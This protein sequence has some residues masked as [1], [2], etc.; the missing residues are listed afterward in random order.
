MTDRLDADPA[1]PTTTYAT[2]LATD[3]AGR[4][5]SISASSVFSGFATFAYRFDGLVGKRVTPN[6]E[7][8]TFAYDALRRPITITKANGN[9]FS[10]TYDRD[11][12]VLTEAR[13]LTGPTGDNGSNTNTFSYDALGRVTGETGLASARTYQY[14]LD[15]NRTRKIEGTTTPTIDY[16][17]DRT[18]Q[19]IKQKV[20]GGAD[21]TLAYNA[22]GDLLTNRDS[23]GA[24]TTYAYDTASHLKSI[25]SGG[26]TATFAFD[27]LGRYRQR[28]VGAVIDKYRYVGTSETTAVIAG[29]TTR[30]SAVSTDGSRVATKDGSTA[31]YLLPDLH[32]NVAAMEQAGA[33]TI[34]NAIRYDAYGQTMGTPYTA[35]GSIKLDTKYQGRLDVSPGTDPL[36]DMSARFYSPAIGAFTS[37]DSVAGT[38]QNPA[39]MNRFLYALGNPASLIDPTGHYPNPLQICPFGPE[40]CAGLDYHPPPGMTSHG[41]GTASSA[42]SGSGGTARDPQDSPVTTVHTPTTGT[43]HTINPDWP[44]G[45]NR[46]KWINDTLEHDCLGGS[47]RACNLYY[48]PAS[49]MGNSECADDLVACI[50][51]LAGGATLA[52]SGPVIEAGASATVDAATTLVTTAI[53]TLRTLLDKTQ[54]NPPLI[55]EI[56]EAGASVPGYG[57]TWSQ[58]PRIVQAGREYAEM[59]RYLF[60]KHAVDNMLP[61][62]QG[63]RA[64]PPSVVISALENAKPVI[65]QLVDGIQRYSYSF[66]GVV[67]IFEPS[68]NVVVTVIPK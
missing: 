47:R 67:V 17:Y 58:L 65:G 54:S 25:V 35:T 68:T 63:G 31:A 30:I 60:T 61:F 28:T 42:G 50:T 48:D 3:W 18:D 5:T 55:D 53:A 1:T 33:V 8:L 43:V 23:A 10:Q 2:A 20:N 45:V 57:A 24:S 21:Q 15:G 39:T 38:A 51:F 59:G 11:S 52:G 40:D 29:A 4:T 12:N 27:A 46:V 37:L 14:D 34:A 44:S 22:Y 13:S 49:W 7:T 9:T 6:A 62:G 19:L 16:Y 64:V 56:Q 41:P 66:G 26:S 36:Y 32:G